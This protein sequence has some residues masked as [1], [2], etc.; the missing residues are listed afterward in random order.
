V[1]GTPKSIAYGA[2][3]T[4]VDEVRRCGER[5]RPERQWSCTTYQQCTQAVVNGS[6]NAFGLSILLRGI[7]TR[8]PELRAK[9]R[10]KETHGGGVV[11]TAIVGL[12]SENRKAK[13][14][15]DISN[16]R[17]DSGEHI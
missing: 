9:R 13:L 11:F 15:M 10:E 6:K 14:C 17:T 1:G 4:P 2:A 3:G 16:E 8:E 7:G 12:K 5:L